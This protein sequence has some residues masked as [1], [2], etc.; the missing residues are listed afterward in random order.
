MSTNPENLVKI[1]VVGSEISLFHLKLWKRRRK[2]VTAVE[3]MPAVLQPGGLIRTDGSHV[4][5]IF[6]MQIR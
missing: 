5:Q 2:K 3:H 4:I 1:G 6:V